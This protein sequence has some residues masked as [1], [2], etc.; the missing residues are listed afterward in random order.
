VGVATTGGV[1]RFVNF[2][3][4]SSSNLADLQ[5]S[6]NLPLQFPTEVYVIGQATTT[7]TSVSAINA[8]QKSSLVDTGNF[9]SLD[10][11]GNPVSPSYQIVPYSNLVYLIRAVTNVK[12][13]NAVGNVGVI[14]GFLVD[15]FVPSTT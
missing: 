3:I 6:N 11:K 15:T 9:I 1:P 14:S 5:L 7:L 12:A 8:S 4:D 13:L 10:D 2:S